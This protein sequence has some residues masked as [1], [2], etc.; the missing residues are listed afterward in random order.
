MP[1]NPT[2]P[3][4][5]GLTY[6]PVLPGTYPSIVPFSIR[7]T[8]SM[9]ILVEEMRKWINSQLVPYVN[10]AV[11][12]LSRDWQI[13]AEMLI[14][15]W[16]AK[17]TQLEADVAEAV[18]R[19]T[20]QV[21]QAEAA[22]QAA[23]AAR[24]QA[25]IYASQAE[26]IQDLAIKTIA[27]NPASQTRAL[28]DG[29]YAKLSD[30]NASTV[31]I[32]A[33]DSL[34]STGRLSDAAVTNKVSDA[35][36][37]GV[38]DRMHVFNPMNFGAVQSTVR[39]QTNASANDAAFSACWNAA[40]A[41]GGG[42]ILIPA[43]YYPI[44][45]WVIDVAGQ[46]KA[47]RT[48]NVHIDGPGAILYGMPSDISAGTSPGQPIVY[49]GASDSLDSDNLFRGIK[50]T[51]LSVQGDLVPIDSGAA[52]DRSGITFFNTQEVTL[53]KVWVSYFK[54]HG[55]LFDGMM[56]STVTDSSVFHCG[57]GSRYAVVLNTSAN[58]NPNAIRF[59]GFHVENC[60]LMLDVD[61][62]TIG[63]R[64]RHV[65]FIGSKFE[66][67]AV[68]YTTNSP[69][70]L[71]QAG[72]VVF[73]DC[74]FVITTFEVFASQIT[75]YF[76]SSSIDTSGINRY[77]RKNVRFLGCDFATP[78]NTAARWVGGPNNTAAGSVGFTDC[79]FHSA[80]GITGWGPAFWLGDDSYMRDCDIIVANTLE[81]PAATPVGDV[82]R[83]DGV[84]AKVSNP[85]L[86]Y[87]AGFAGT[88]LDVAVNAQKCEFKGWQAP[89]GKPTT[90]VKLPG[91]ETQLGTRVFTDMLEPGAPWLAP[92]SP[93][94]FGLFTHLTCQ[95]GTYIDFI[96][97]CAG[98]IITLTPQDSG[99]FTVTHSGNLRL[100]GH[101]SRTISWGNS[102]SLIY[103]TSGYWREM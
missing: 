14:A 43:G 93:S 50:I 27:N 81:N 62:P 85:I 25:A 12:D 16:D 67:R 34:T 35:V 70:R 88:L 78:S 51:G 42:T 44:N 20:D 32:D 89:H 99:S 54:Y 95:N 31:R 45:K 11:K 52:I 76:I 91:T 69:V 74:L 30:F 64:S 46:V 53:E 57:D 92:G 29:L 48:V 68:N 3:V 101:A 84:S 79:T 26:A 90:L 37:L 100:A 87:P 9:I 18:A 10:N 94:V 58:T 22:Q 39:N 17:M 41:A 72:E 73:S 59:L 55:M 75:P 13:Y 28:L 60:G 56:D 98:Q 49:I 83:L 23:E 38:K 102:I 24:D 66:R 61:G 7:E 82:F 36:T 96:Q 97:A 65:Y 80:T 63:T 15:A 19:M 40:F 2:P 33:L 8:P 71:S 47:R 86:F 4:I 103:S 5:P 1:T 77:A 21:A 6:P